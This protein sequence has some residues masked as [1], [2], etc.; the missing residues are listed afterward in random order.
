MCFKL[1]NGRIYGITGDADLV[2]EIALLLVGAKV[3]TT[4]SV[5]I[6]GFDLWKESARAKAYLGFVPRAYATY[7]DIT[8]LEYLLFFTDVRQIEYELGIR[9]I[10]DALGAVGL[11]HKRD[12]LIKS[13]SDYEKK[14]LTLAQALLSQAQILVLENPFEDL[15]AQDAERFAH[16]L[17]SISPEKTLILCARTPHYLRRMCG[18]CY[19]ATASELLSDEDVAAKED[20]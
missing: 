4:G 14:C 8:P 9:R 11:S 6:N 20:C 16:L 13:L 18:V 2:R 7:L 12:L 5:Q 10:G 3:P 15:N 1:N 17:E 19:R